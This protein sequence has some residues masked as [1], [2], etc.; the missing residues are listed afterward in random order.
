MVKAL[1]YWRQLNHESECLVC[2]HFILIF[3][4]K[5]GKPN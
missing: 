1:K 5:L 3:N 4:G 2:L